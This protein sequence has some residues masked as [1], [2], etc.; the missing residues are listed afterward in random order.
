MQKFKR[1]KNRD[2]SEVSGSMFLVIAGEILL[3]T[4]IIMGLSAIVTILL[5][6]CTRSRLTTNRRN[7][8]FAEAFERSDNRASLTSLQQ[9]ILEK[10]RDRP[11][12]YETRHN[13]E[14]RRREQNEEGNSSQ[15]EVG[16]RSIAILNP[17]A[18]CV[19][20]PPYETDSGEL[21]VCSTTF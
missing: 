13:Y 18:G 6:M 4:A 19:P 11:P 16:I 12:R 21:S 7:L 2:N 14:Y 17:G 10:M 5:R 15:Q 20:P 8:R 3:G 9:R 1:K